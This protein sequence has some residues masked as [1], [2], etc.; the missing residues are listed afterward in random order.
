MLEAEQ[1]NEFHFQ[2]R[3]TAKNVEED[4][5][6]FEDEEDKYEKKEDVTSSIA[7]LAKKIQETK[8][9]Q[10]PP[11]PPQHEP[12]KTQLSNDDDLDIDIE[13]DNVDT[14]DVNLDDDLSDD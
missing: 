9:S 4:D 1:T 7:D 8:L 6:E 5:D 3:T 11:K 13:L 10:S 14:T 12:I 2:H